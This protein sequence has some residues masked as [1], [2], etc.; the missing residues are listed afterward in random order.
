MIVKKIKKASLEGKTFISLA[1]IWEI[2]LSKK[3]RKTLIKASSNRC[4][5][6][7]WKMKTGFLKLGFFI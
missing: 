2:N 7:F 6:G 4:Q 1:V 3:I 5:S